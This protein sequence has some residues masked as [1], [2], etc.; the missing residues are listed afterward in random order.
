MNTKLITGCALS[1]LVVAGG[2]ATMV[3]AQTVAEATNL[4]E[5][6]VIEI[7]LMEVPGEL[8]EVEL[9]DSRK[10]QIYEVE[11]TAEDGTEVEVEIAASTGE[12]LKVEAD[13]EG[14]DKDDDGDRA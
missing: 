10:G 12:V 14:C 7:A 9:E 11:I 6:Q 3:S 2:I 8:M 5:E 4:T 13:G 1:G